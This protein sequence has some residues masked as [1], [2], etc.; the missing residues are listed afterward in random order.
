M[1]ADVSSVSPLLLSFMMPL[2]LPSSVDSPVSLGFG[3]KERCIK[4]VSN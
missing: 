2:E 4:Y 1:L 3:G